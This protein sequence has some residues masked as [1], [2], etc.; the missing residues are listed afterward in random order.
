MATAA[1]C[2]CGDAPAGLTPREAEVAAQV[3]QGLTNKQI[4]AWSAQRS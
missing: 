4:A 3:A 2:P 1:T